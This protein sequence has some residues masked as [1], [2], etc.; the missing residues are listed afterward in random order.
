MDPPSLVSAVRAGGGALM[1]WGM[2][3]WHAL[4]LIIPVVHHLNA[5]AYL[6][7]AADH[8]LPSSSNG[9][10]QHGDAPC[11]KQNLFQ[12]GFMN[13]TRSSMIFS[14]L[15]SHRIWIQTFG[16]WQNR[17]FAAGMR[18]WQEIVWYNHVNMDQDHKGMFPT[19][20][21]IYATKRLF[22]DQ[23]K[24]LPSISIVFLI[25]CSIECTSAK[26]LKLHWI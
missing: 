9:Y 25:K 1:V 5:T 8:V 21:G 17:R 15:S 2:F 24:P 19:S 18:R 23:N 12:T 4:S 14:G 10:F 26:A 3:S 7:I 20:C 22:L 16:M 11:K 13:V 6:N